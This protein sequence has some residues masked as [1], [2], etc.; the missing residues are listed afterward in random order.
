MCSSS[1][2]ARSW[3]GRL[4]LLIAIVVA[5][6]IGIHLQ[7]PVGRG[8]ALPQ[9]RRFRLCRTSVR[10]R[11]LVL[12]VH[13]ARLEDAGQLRR[14]RPALHVHRHRPH[15]PRRPGHGAERQEQRPPRTPRQGASVGDPG[16]GHG[17]QSRRLH[18]PDVGSRLLDEGRGVRRQLHRRQRLPARAPL[19]GHRVAGRR[20]HL[21]RQHPV[22]GLETARRSRSS[23][24]S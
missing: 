3:P 20:S 13:P 21:L 6:V 2:P 16:L 7:R 1:S 18:D 14:H 15:L 22:Q 8:T 19:P 4:L 12:R 10:Q 9:P 17:G 5:I 24:C 23:S 11:R